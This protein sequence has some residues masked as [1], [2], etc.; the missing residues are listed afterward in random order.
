[1]TAIHDG[2]ER[3]TKAALGA[4]QPAPSPND[5]GAPAPEAA[6]PRPAHQA[7]RR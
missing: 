5:T 6:D 7:E 3:V 2:T 4:V 1:M